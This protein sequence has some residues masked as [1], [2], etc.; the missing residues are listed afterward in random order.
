MLIS[1][2]SLNLPNINFMNEL[3]TKQFIPVHRIN[4]VD[5][6]HIDVVRTIISACK[7]ASLKHTHTHE[8]P[9]EGSLSFHWI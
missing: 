3:I 7:L 2:S 4:A 5:C 8:M 6:I 9:N 1:Q